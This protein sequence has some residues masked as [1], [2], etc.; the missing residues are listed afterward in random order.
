MKPEADIIT[1]NAL[2]SSKSALNVSWLTTI[3]L[4]LNP[5]NLTILNT[6]KSLSAWWYF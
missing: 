1:Y 5:I 2:I 4:F 3:Q 6:T